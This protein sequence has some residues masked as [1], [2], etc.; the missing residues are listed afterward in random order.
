MI[1][2]TGATGFLGRAV[3]QALL[4]QDYP[5]CILPRSFKHIPI[6]CHTLLHM[7]GETKRT[8]LM[9]FANIEVTQYLLKIA[10]G[11]AVEKVVY[12]S[13]VAVTHYE[14]DC[15]QSEYAR[16]KT[17]AEYLVKQSSLPSICLRIGTVYSGWGWHSWPAQALKSLLKGE[18]VAQ[19]E[20]LDVVVKKIVEAVHG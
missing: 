17:A 8:E 4:T 10:E 6:S 20:S 3:V 16:T 11:S 5:V 9:H 15:N 13:S 7:A 14:Y 1:A 18:S 12:L 2:V 19:M